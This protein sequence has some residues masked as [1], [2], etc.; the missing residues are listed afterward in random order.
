LRLR[1]VGGQVPGFLDDG[2]LVVDQ[3]ALGVVV[4]LGVAVD[5]GVEQATGRVHEGHAVTLEALLEGTADLHVLLP[6]ALPQLGDLLAVGGQTGL[7]E[8]VLAVADGHRADVG[9]ETEHLAV[10]GGD[11]GLL[12]GQEVVGAAEAGEVR[13]LVGLGV[14]DLLGPADLDA[15]DVL[16]TLASGQPRLQGR[17][18]GLL[19]TGYLGLDVDVRVLLLVLLQKPRLLEAHHPVHPHG[20][21]D[22]AVLLAAARRRVVTGST[23]DDERERA[24]GGGDR[25]RPGARCPASSAH[26]FPPRDG[27]G[28]PGWRCGVGTASR[29]WERAHHG[30]GT[31]PPMDRRLVVPSPSCQWLVNNSRRNRASGVRFLAAGG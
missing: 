27:A 6:V 25:D 28:A 4:L 13:E 22:L 23:A 14:D 2:V 17:V 12:P 11:L 21:G 1:G 16:Q 9:A 26:D 30:V 10:G 29:W 15:L 7:L 24:D 5:H 31:C 18:V 3:V 8:V 20:D 19:V